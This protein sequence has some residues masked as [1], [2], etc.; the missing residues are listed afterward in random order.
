MVVP[1]PL[2][3]LCVLVP[4]DRALDVRRHSMTTRKI[5]WG[6]CLITL[7]SVAPILCVLISSGIASATGSRLDEAGAHLCIILGVD[8][9]GVLAAMFVCGWFMLVTIPTGLIAMLIFTIVWIVQ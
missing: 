8:V 5:I 6:Y 3:G 1:V 4:R 7:Y 9:G 2:C